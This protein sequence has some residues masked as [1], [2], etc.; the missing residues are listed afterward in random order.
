MEM[1]FKLWSS[2]ETQNQNTTNKRKVRSDL[3]LQSEM[4]E[5]NFGQTPETPKKANNGLLNFT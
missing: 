2:D 5:S 3:Q 4:C 1:H